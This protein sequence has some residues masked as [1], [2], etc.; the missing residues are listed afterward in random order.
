MNFNGASFGLCLQTSLV[1]AVVSIRESWRLVAPKCFHELGSM[2]KF[3]KFLC[4]VTSSAILN[5]SLVINSLPQSCGI[6]TRQRGIIG[7]SGWHPVM[8]LKTVLIFLI[9]RLDT[10]LPIVAPVSNEI[11]TVNHFC[12]RFSSI[13]R[14]RPGRVQR[15]RISLRM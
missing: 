9:Q 2:L 3:A 12:G 4:W 15:E 6:R 5:Q 8:K 13:T 14:Q 1:R 11:I 10:A 7:L